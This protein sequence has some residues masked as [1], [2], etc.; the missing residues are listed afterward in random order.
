MTV[1]DADAHVLETEETWE[2]MEPSDRK[3]RPQ[4][5]T[6]STARFDEQEFW[7]IDGKIRRRNQPASPNNSC[8][9]NRKRLAVMS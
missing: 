9:L 7:F 8:L 6:V 4:V 1:I 5:R 3:Y 2:Y